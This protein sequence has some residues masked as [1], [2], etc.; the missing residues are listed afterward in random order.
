MERTPEAVGTPFQYENVWPSGRLLL[1]FLFQCFSTSETVPGRLLVNIWN[2]A[3]DQ[4]GSGDKFD[5]LSAAKLHPRLEYGDSYARRRHGSTRKMTWPAMCD[6]GDDDR[7]FMFSNILPASAAGISRS[8]QLSSPWQGRRY[9]P[10][11]QAVRSLRAGGTVRQGR[12]YGPSGQAVRT[13]HPSTKH[14]CLST[15][16]QLSRTGRRVG[17]A[18][19]RL[20]PLCSYIWEAA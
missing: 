1:S 19:Y 2:K 3:E 7:L 16:L 5:L 13:V 10:S 8:S 4:W 17:P 14:T 6:F 9:G 20:R 12:R 18:L 11:G 15:I